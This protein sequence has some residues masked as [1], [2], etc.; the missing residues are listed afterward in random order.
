MP[1]AP[2]ARRGRHVGASPWAKAAPAKPSP[3]AVPAS[4]QAAA[5]AATAADATEGTDLDPDEVQEAREEF[6]KIT[7]GTLQMQ[8]EEMK[9]YWRLVG[10]VKHQPAALLR[11]RAR[12]DIFYAQFMQWPSKYRGQLFETDLQVRRAWQHDPNRDY[13]GK[14]YELWGISHESR[15]RFYEIVTPDLPEGFPLGPEVEA[16]VR[17]VGYFLKL[18]GYIPGAAR[19]GDRPEMAPLLVGHVIWNAPAAG[20]GQATGADWLWVAMM[21]ALVAA[22]GVVSLG[23]MLWGRKKK[24]ASSLVR[25]AGSRRGP[26]PSIDQWMEQAGADPTGNNPG[27]P[28]EYLFGEPGPPSSGDGSDNGHGPSEGTGPSGAGPQGPGPVGPNP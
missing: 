4:K 21:V 9:A 26:A 23:F 6:E 15:S 18:Q 13:D 28:P 10:W 8:P 7:D 14:I 19:P 16:N 22:V 12:S 3:A 24:P 20:G 17:V 25:L 2:A 27:P 11:Q 1:T 5:D